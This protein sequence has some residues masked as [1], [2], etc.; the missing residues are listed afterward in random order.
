MR[1][2]DEVYREFIVKYPGLTIFEDALM[3]F[4][5][6]PISK[7][8]GSFV[9]PTIILPAYLSLIGLIP[10][11]PIWST[12]AE[13][14]T[15]QGTPRRTSYPIQVRERR[16]FDP[17]PADSYSTT[18]MSTRIEDQHRIIRDQIN[19][20]DLD[21]LTNLSTNEWVRIY[22]AMMFAESRHNPYAVSSAG[23]AGILQLMPFRAEEF[24]A[25]KVYDTPSFNQWLR[26]R[27]QMEIADRGGRE[28]DY[29]RY[30]AEARQISDSYAQRLRAIV[31]QNR[32][33]PK[34]LGDTD[35]RFSDQIFPMSVG[36]MRKNILLASEMEDSG[37]IEERDI[38]TVAIVHYHGGDL[39]VQRYL[40]GNPISNGYLN[41]I[42]T[43]SGVTLHRRR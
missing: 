6:L 13:A 36:L 14:A 21:D 16:W 9:I 3:N 4:S 43:R 42:E 37:L 40:A 8:T 2:I 28:E 32:N 29:D 17:M 5:K 38:P 19:A 26:L 41:R 11:T 34:V 15:I 23:A 18:N 1:G 30:R 31:R 22:D 27:E 7:K 35:S 24:G 20:K 12:S 10:N 33:N 25:S 39:A